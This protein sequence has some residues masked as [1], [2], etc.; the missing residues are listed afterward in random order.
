VRK[1]GMRMSKRIDHTVIVE[2]LLTLTR[3]RRPAR[4]RDLKLVT[5]HCTSNPPQ[6]GARCHA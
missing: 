3:L 1:S 6:T 5:A 4:G 2:A